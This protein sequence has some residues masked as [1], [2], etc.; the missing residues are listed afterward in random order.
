MHHSALNRQVSIRDA[1][2]LRRRRGLVAILLLALWS[3]CAVSS[4]ASPVAMQSGPERG[5]PDPGWFRSARIGGLSLTP[6]RLTLQQ[7]EE[8]VGEL[9]N[10]GVNV[11][12]GESSLSEYLTEAE[13]ATETEM[14]AAFSQV[15]HQRQLKVVWKL[16][17]LEVVTAEGR[18]R[19]HSMAKD[20]P[21]WLQLAFDGETRSR[22]YG[23]NS[24][25][26]LV[27]DEI[28]WMCPNGPF[29]SY[30]FRKLETLAR[31]GVDAILLG[32]ARFDPAGSWS[33]T[34]VHCRARFTAETGQTFPD[35]INLSD[36]SFY[37]FLRWRHRTLADFLR[38]CSRVVRAASAGTEAIAEV[39]TVDHLGASETGLDGAHL[40]GLP[41]LW[42]IDPISEVTAMADGDT[43]DWFSLMAAGKWGQGAAFPRSSWSLSMG[44]RASDAGLALASCLAAQLN[45]WEMR[46]PVPASTVGNRFRARQYDWIRRHSD[47]LFQSASIA[48]V[49]VLYSGASRDLLDGHRQGGFFDTWES[50]R[51]D[52]K[53]SLGSRS[54]TVESTEYLS[55][56]RGWTRLLIGHN[57]PFDVVPAGTLTP[58]RLDPYRFV[59]FPEGAVV[60]EGT[61][62]ILLNW[63]HGGGTLLITGVR[64]GLYDKRGRRRTPSI[65]E[66]AISVNG[67]DDQAVRGRRIDRGEVILWNGSPG[68][69]ILQ[70]H[71]PGVCQAALQWM[72]GAGVRPWLEQAGPIYVQ[73]YERPGETIVHGVHHGWTGKRDNVPTPIRAAFSIPMPGHRR[74]MQV[75]QTSPDREDVSI[76][77]RQVSDTVSFS[78][79]LGIHSLFLVKWELSVR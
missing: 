75:L 13:Q 19:R 41:V 17:T 61:R 74:V 45:P 70:G 44:W 40:G 28:A 73:A 10:S 60:D 76:P 67:G 66:E 15:A 22:V 36:P 64:Q 59:I 31:T 65:W 24:D 68:A 6:F 46:A 4:T 62:D 23:S 32:E 63:V 71:R 34:D 43:G 2:I 21:E 47:S 37:A 57:L 26:T 9:V 27:N 77:Y 39:D 25:P 16:A 30:L 49:A 35:S 78:A 5:A 29:R 3:C 50:P 79:E 55:E 72:A 38:D 48:P 20:H 69:S 14:I 51:R 54:E 52:L 18:K 42:K 53:W 7:M 8:S 1:V 58:V 11:V 12:V 33:C 56:Y